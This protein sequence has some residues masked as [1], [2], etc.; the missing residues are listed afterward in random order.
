MSRVVSERSENANRAA[1]SKIEILCSFFIKLNK[2]GP[3]LFS[4]FA[5][6]P[7]FWKL[8]RFPNLDSTLQ[9]QKH[10]C[11]PYYIIAFVCKFWFSFLCPHCCLKG[12]RRRR[13]RRSRSVVI[14]YEAKRR[15]FVGRTDQFRLLLGTDSTSFGVVGSRHEATCLSCFL[16]SKWDE[17]INLWELEPG[18][19]V[20]KGEE[21][22][23]ICFYLSRKMQCCCC[24]CWG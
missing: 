22:V 5:L 8:S 18:E 14:F 6:I 20:K 19:M 21:K 9:Q 15:G 12:W 10:P 2:K 3:I 24:C 4:Y 23:E 17:G 13:R 7:I 11:F 1:I 16:V